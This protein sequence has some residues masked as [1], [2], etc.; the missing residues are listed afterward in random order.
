MAI[1]NIKISLF[2]FIFSY[3]LTY[4][5]ISLCTYFVP[6]FTPRYSWWGLCCSSFLVFF[7]VLSC[8]FTFWAPCCVVRYDFRKNRKFGS[9][10]PP[11]VCKRVM[12]HLRHFCLFGI[13]VS[14]TYCVV[15]L[16]C[17][18]SSCLP[19]VVSFSGLSIFDCPFGIYWTY[20]CH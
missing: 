11:V 1:I 2:L 3:I 12:S 17:L 5:Y 8:V 13:V 18:S 14:N 19:C 15:C 9:S 4:I 20:S 6:E 7:V 10:L 16:C